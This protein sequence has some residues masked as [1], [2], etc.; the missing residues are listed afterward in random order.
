MS[1]EPV[2]PIKPPAA[3]ALDGDRVLIHDLSVDGA[4][5]ALV[6]D[7]VAAGRDPELVVRQALEVG[8]AVL[9]HGAAKGTV[10]AVSA[11]VDRL[12]TALDEKSSRIEAV[13]R[14]RERIAAKG[15]SFEAALPPVLDGCFAPH[16]DVVEATGATRGIAEQKVDDFAVVVNP[17]D[18]G[19]RDRRIVFE[20]KDRMM[21]L[22]KALAELEAAMLN[23]NAVVGVLVFAHRAQAPLAGK[24][25][26]A[27]PGN[28][29]MVVWDTE[30]DPDHLALEV[31][32]QLARTLAIAAQAEDAKLN[33]RGVGTRIE[34]LINVVERADAIRR[35]ISGARSGLDA[36][37]DAYY[38]MNEQALE[39]LLELQDRI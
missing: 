32:A 7:A 5:A 26:R 20:A 24:P 36:A 6:Q 13:K 31:A 11:E 22:P 19:G 27:F 12:L 3:V 35:G 25:L 28:K 39:L 29:L 2:P 14:L 10:D 1:V 16:N 33:R 17:R 37:E 23:R 21:S 30:A 8:A 38:E 4:L 9:S 18:T 15:L 34:K